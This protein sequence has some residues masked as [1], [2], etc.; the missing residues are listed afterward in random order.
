[1]A[2]HSGE[3]FA[4]DPTTDQIAGRYDTPGC[5]QPHGLSIDSTRRLAFVA[6]EGYSRLLVIEMDTMQATNAYDTGRGPD[7]L[8]LEPQQGILYVA[9]EDGVL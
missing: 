9:A 8:A 3:L 4:I 6:S 5:D 2:V 1:V 7:V